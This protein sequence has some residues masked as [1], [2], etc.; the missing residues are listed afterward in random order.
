MVFKS[1]FDCSELNGCQL[2]SPILKEFV[3]KNITYN[4]QEAEAS[5]NVIDSPFED[6]LQFKYIINE[7][8]E[9]DFSIVGIDKGSLYND[10]LFQ[11]NTK[12]GFRIIYRL[13]SFGHF[14]FS[15]GVYERDKFAFNTIEPMEVEYQLEEHL[16]LHNMSGCLS[17]DIDE[18]DEFTFLAVPEIEFK[19]WG[20]FFINVIKKFIPE[21]K[22]PFELQTRKE[23]ER[24][25]GSVQSS[26]VDQMMKELAK[27]QM[28]IRVKQDTEG[29]LGEMVILGDELVD[30]KKKQFKMKAIDYKNYDYIE[31]V[32]Q[33][34]FFFGSAMLQKYN[35][36]FYYVEYDLGYEFL[37]S[38]DVETDS[39]Y[40]DENGHRVQKESFF[41]AWVKYLLV[42]L[43]ICVVGY[44]FWKVYK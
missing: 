32:E 38:Y 26:K 14:K 22:G 31:G 21:I 23:V 3:F 44:F 35:Y 1:D 33:C 6:K 9:D 24:L 11:Q 18:L 30:I 8:K 28:K 7:K 4:Y 42:C 40:I 19:N 39:F 29:V 2:K 25:L 20:M 5:V 41:R 16:Q 36:K 37:F 34:D 27:F 15:Y 43:V 17:N 13:D 12:K 10:Y